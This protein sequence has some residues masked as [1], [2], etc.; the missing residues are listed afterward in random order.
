MVKIKQADLI[1]YQKNMK[2]VRIAVIG[3]VM[4]D[5]YYWG[6]TERISPEAPVPVVNITDEEIKPGGAA[7]V[8]LNIKSLGAEPMMFGIIGS[9]LYGVHFVDNLTENR[10]DVKYILVDSKRPTTVK[11]R[12]LASNQHVVRFDKENSA[13]ISKKNENKL[14]SLIEKN[15]DGV[16]AVIFED[17]NKGLL[18]PRVI[19]S[20]I[21]MCR[22]RNIITS[23][24]PKIKNIL[25][26]KGV[27]IFKPNLR[28][29]EDILKRKIKTELE[30]EKA[31]ADLM[32]KL[33]LKKLVITLSERGMAVFNEN[34]IMDIIPAR[35]AKIANVSGAGDTVIATLVSFLC[36]GATFNEACTIANY[37]ASIVVEDVSIIPVDPK[38]LSLRLSESGGLIGK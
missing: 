29:T 19:R 28:E 21:E 11:T 10:I 8:A 1:K 13:D 4:L 23:V 9:D 33:D 26:Y 32:E 2:N 38:V 15:I 22:K 20:V 17:Y 30:I 25:S 31:G 36:A 14:L 27:T 35:S 24:D 18:T 3:D 16:N 12:I 34:A 5:I 37:A 7:N 6:K